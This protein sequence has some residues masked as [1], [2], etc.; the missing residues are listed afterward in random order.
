MSDITHVIKAA[1]K[2]HQSKDTLKLMTEKA[3]GR[4][5]NDFIEKELAGG[6]CYAVYLVQ[7][8]EEKYV[9]KIAPHPESKV[10]MRHEKD[11]LL[12]E[13]NSLRLF[14][15]KLDIPAPKLLLL[16]TTRTIC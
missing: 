12:N 6:M 3:L 13:A 8:D 11:N 7:A 4:T 2:F 16:D 5:T 9:I 10:L 15:E 14:E 1:S